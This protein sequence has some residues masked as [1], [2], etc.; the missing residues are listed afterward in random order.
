VGAAGERATQAANARV[1]SIYRLGELFRVAGPDAALEIQKIGKHGRVFLE[2]HLFW[3]I[4]GGRFLA[5]RN[6]IPF[7]YLRHM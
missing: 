6:R 7:F 4:Q 1:C 5:F 3:Y 2:V